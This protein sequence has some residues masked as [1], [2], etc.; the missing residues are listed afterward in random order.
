[1]DKKRIIKSVDKF[2][3]K[4]SKKIR[5]DNVVVFGSQST[6]TA[7]KDSDIDIIVISKDFT[8]W[9]EEKRLDILYKA[10]MFIVPEIHPWGVTPEEFAAADPQST[11]GHARQE[12]YRFSQ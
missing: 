3:K 4:I 10:S 12:G 5:V 2:L 7:Q 6:N 1:M 11:I 8:G 9:N